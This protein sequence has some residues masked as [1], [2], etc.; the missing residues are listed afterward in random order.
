MFHGHIIW[1]IIFK[2]N[3]QKKSLGNVIFQNISTKNI[4]TMTTP[5]IYFYVFLFFIIKTSQRFNY[6]YADTAII[7]D[8]YIIPCFQIWLHCQHTRSSKSLRS[9]A[10]RTAA[11]AAYQNSPSAV[12]NRYQRTSYSCRKVSGHFDAYYAHTYNKS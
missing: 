7:Y 3:L 1:K 2:S 5:I 8:I 12:Y 10:K 4:L 6:I 9:F 11:W